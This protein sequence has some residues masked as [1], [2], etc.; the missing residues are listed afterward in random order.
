[1]SLANKVLPYPRMG[2]DGR[3]NPFPS[4]SLLPIFLSCSLEGNRWA[5]VGASFFN[6]HFSV[7]LVCCSIIY[8]FIWVRG[9]QFSSMLKLGF[10]LTDSV[11]LDFLSTSIVT[12]VKWVESLSL[13]QIVH[14][15]VR[16][17]IS[18][19]S[20]TLIAVGPNSYPTGS[21]LDSG[22]GLLLL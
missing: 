2:D 5:V 8:P 11:I 15:P 16:S 17:C 22:T 18:P 12:S 21:W 10:G 7:E 4:P 9:S 20:S 14:N 19:V 3:K 13:A 1:M 6:S